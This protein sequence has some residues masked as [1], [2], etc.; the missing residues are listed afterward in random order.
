MSEH[1]IPN[2]I[3]C[4]SLAKI[5]DDNV[6]ICFQQYNISNS[7]PSRMSNAPHNLFVNF[8]T[9][10]ILFINSLLALKYIYRRICKFAI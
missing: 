7:K 8:V 9:V 6:F 2:V 1:N 4:K 5:S 10:L 3:I